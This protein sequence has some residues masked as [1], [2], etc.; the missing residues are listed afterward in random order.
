MNS[1]P[2]SRLRLWK[3]LSDLFLDTEVSEPTYRYIARVIEEDGYTREEA[4]RILWQEVYPVLEGNLRSVAGVW[5]GWPD[6][7]LLQHLKISSDAL[8][9]S[10]MTGDSVIVSEI[11]SCW[12]RVLAYLP[13]DIAQASDAANIREPNS[14]R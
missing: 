14:D 13:A 7:W 12:R 5:A 6:E 4:E 10:A 8:P 2:G 1:T 9:R 3:A 11:N